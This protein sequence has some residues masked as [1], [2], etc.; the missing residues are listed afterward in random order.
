MC[1]QTLVE[2]TSKVTWRDERASQS[3]GYNNNAGST[4]L[5]D[6]TLLREA[7]PV[8]ELACSGSGESIP[9]DMSRA[10]LVV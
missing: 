5:E 2:P 9:V 8:F 10:Q 4:H 6:E 3:C 7:A 1:F